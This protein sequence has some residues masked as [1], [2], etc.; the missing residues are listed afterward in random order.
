MR[1][2]VEVSQRGPG[3]VRVRRE[4]AACKEVERAEEKDDVSEA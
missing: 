3:G 1:V 2:R 4:S